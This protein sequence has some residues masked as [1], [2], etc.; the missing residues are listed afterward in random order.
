[1]CQ[2][3]ACAIFINCCF[4]ACLSASVCRVHGSLFLVL[5][6]SSSSS[7]PSS[8]HPF[9]TVIVAARRWRSRQ[10]TKSHPSSAGRKI[11]TWAPPLGERGRLLSIGWA[12]CD[13]AVDWACLCL[14]LRLLS[15]HCPLLRKIV[16]ASHPHE[17]IRGAVSPKTPSPE[18]SLI[19]VHSQLAHTAHLY[20]RYVVH[21][22]LEQGE[23]PSGKLTCRTA[24]QGQ[25]HVCQ[26][27]KDRRIEK[28]MVRAT[29]LCCDDSYALS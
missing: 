4:L 9:S 7:S 26:T 15:L 16:H 17:H 13:A 11:S 21:Y 24:K 5:L 10:S 1:M 18:C 29:Q 22:L 20:H 12:C 28:L 23:S 2:T 19:L 3:D 14:M 27:G 25:T 8:L 6:F